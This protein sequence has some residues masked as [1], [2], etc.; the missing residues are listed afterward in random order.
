VRNASGTG[1]RRPRVGVVDLIARKATRSPYA[2]LMNANYA[3]IMP[4]V[5]ATWAE[6]LGC[7]V[8]YDTFTG[9]EDLRR[10]L[11]RDVDILFLSAFTPAA[12]LAY[13]IASLYRRRGVV[14]VLGGP[15][16]RAYP[17]DARRHFDYV[18]GFTD[19]P[20]IR[21]LLYHG[22]PQPLGGV[23]VSAARQPR[24]L[25]GVR[26]RWRFPRQALAK[27]RLIASVP[28]L[29]S[30]GCPYDCSFCIDAT[31]AYQTLPYE[32]IREDLVF[33]TQQLERPVVGWHDPNFGVRFDEYMA[34]IDAAVRPGTVRFVA[35]SSLSLLTEPHLKALAARGFQGLVVG[36]ESWFG[37]GA[38]ARQRANVGMVKAEAVGRHVD[39]VTRHIP[40]VQTN[41]VW[42]LDDDV[43][44]EPFEL[45]R[46]FM[47][48]APAAFPVHSLFTAFGESAPLSTELARGGR[49][50]DVPYHCQDTSA[51]HN[52]RLKHYSAAELYGL[53]A[54]L[55][56]ECYSPAATL[57]RYRRNPHSWA[58]GSRWMGIVRAMGSAWRGPY[59]AKLRNLFSTDPEFIAFAAGGARAPRSFRA[60]VAA[61]LGPFFYEQLPRE[62]VEDLEGER[63]PCTASE[64]TRSVG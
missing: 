36:I 13:G 34:A 64:P 39:V 62:V 45:T 25:P 37:F 8:Q 52:V 61:E 17:Q 41:F 44:T 30:L 56:Y 33:L 15:H 35:E 3:S 49:V 47:E 40:H 59:Y 31:V 12:Y 7:E 18:A 23:R 4:Q 19:K 6:E 16:A 5:I 28:M 1:R 21:E 26:E 20:L 55:A 22:E 24:E 51:I 32:Q 48:L 57:N 58:S 60:G 10:T 54:D 50:L 27:S 9:F 11:P 2:R 42:G 53:L 43:G 14:T 63:V 38:K 29:G 46:R